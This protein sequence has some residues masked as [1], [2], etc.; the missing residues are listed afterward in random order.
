EE[1]YR[2]GKITDFQKKVLLNDIVTAILYLVIP[3]ENFKQEIIEKLQIP[4]AYAEIIDQ[5]I[6]KMIFEPLK[7]ELEQYKYLLPKTTPFELQKSKEQQPK[8]TSP[9]E[10]KTTPAQEIH[11]QKIEDLLPKTKA[12]E[13]KPKEVP[14]QEPTSEPLLPE[15]PEIKIERPVNKTGELKRVTV[16][17][18]SPEIQERIHSKLMDAIKKKDAQPSIIEAM[19]KVVDKG[20]RQPLD[21]KAQPKNISEEN[22]VAL[23]Q[24]VAGQ[25][26]HF[27]TKETSKKSSEPKPY[28]LDV[29][30]KEEKENKQELPTKEIKYQ[31]PEEKPFGEA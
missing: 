6:Q 15:I 17:S 16:P 3:R 20:V 25:N 21:K 19:K 29:K 14:R 7:D 18:V 13:E 24:V 22:K 9:Q 26:D 10:L 30:I 23:S 4:P 1:A 5:I 28:I 8:I 27:A 12:W 2:F 11:P 31:K